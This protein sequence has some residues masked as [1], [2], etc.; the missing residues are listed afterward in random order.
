MIALIMIIIFNQAIAI[1]STVKRGFEHLITYLEPETIVRLTRCYVRW[2][3]IGPSQKSPL[4]S[5]RYCM[6]PPPMQTDETPPP[7]PV[8][9][10]CEN[11]TF[12]HLRKVIAHLYAKSCTI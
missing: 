5:S 8:S 4:P 12:D 9:S 3:F 11:Y 10:A 1:S 7:L 6:V 2:L